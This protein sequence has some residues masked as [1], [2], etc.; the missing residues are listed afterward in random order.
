MWFGFVRR[1]LT[2]MSSHQYFDLNV[3]YG[4]TVPAEMIHS[5]MEVYAKE[6]FETGRTPNENEEDYEYR[7]VIDHDSLNEF[8]SATFP[9]IYP[10][11]DL[12]GLCE[13]LPRLFYDGDDDEETFV[14]GVRVALFNL[15]SMDTKVFRDL[16]I[17]TELD[18]AQSLVN[19]WIATYKDLVGDVDKRTHYI[20]SF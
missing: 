7:L 11:T 12:D 3:I 4:I 2:N 14:F 1:S 5:R 19:A 13:N 20:V 18:E 15:G 16:G 17:M 8:F 9:C 6:T 10:K